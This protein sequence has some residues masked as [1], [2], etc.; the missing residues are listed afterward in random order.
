VSGD[1]PRLQRFLAEA[2]IAARRK[3]E[4]LIT[5]GRVRVN[6]KVAELG[7][8]VDP[9]RDRVEVD[10][11]PVLV[12]RK[13]YALLNKPRGCVSTLSDPEGRPTVMELLPKQGPRIYPV[14]RLDFNTEGLLLFTNDGDL[15]NGLMHPRREVPKTYHAKLRSIL[16]EADVAAL[17]AGVELDGG[18][19]KA[20]VAGGGTAANGKSSWVEITITEGRNRQIH[21]MLES[22]G[23]EISRLIRVGYG[24]LVVGELRRAKW[25]PLSPEELDGLRELAGLPTRDQEQKRPAGTAKGQARRAPKPGARRSA[26]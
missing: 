20:T 15:A 22:L 2:G 12:E 23:H 5:D 9:V 24:P 7:S 25:R 16:T 26:R 8:R 13:V 4:V 14:G 21:R 3:A 18:V 1:A 6:G 10:G 17:E 19:R 11:K